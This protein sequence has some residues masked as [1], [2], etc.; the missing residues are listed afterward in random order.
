MFRA[1]FY[2]IQ[3]TFQ[4]VTWKFEARLTFLGN[5]W[6][7]VTPY[8]THSKGKPH[9]ASQYLVYLFCSKKQTTVVSDGSLL[10]Q[11]LRSLRQECCNLGFQTNLGNPS[12]AV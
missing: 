2:I 9:T 10:F 12:K 11:L 3:V 4:E 8:L 6:G 5:S 1:R 7:I